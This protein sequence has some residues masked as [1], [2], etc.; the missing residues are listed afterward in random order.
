MPY[1]YAYVLIVIGAI[2]S[3]GDEDYLTAT[4]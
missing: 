1:M 4:L 3:Y 2:H